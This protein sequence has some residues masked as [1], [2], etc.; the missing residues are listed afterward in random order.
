MRFFGRFGLSR[1]P[2]T[3]QLQLAKDMN[4]LFI[5][6]VFIA[7]AMQDKRTSLGGSD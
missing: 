3:A 2:P 1:Q 5:S 7:R 6:N 4:L